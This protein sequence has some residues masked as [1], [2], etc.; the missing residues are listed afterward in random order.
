MKLYDVEISAQNNIA[1]SGQDD[2][3]IFDTS[4]I[5]KRLATEGFKF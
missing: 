3:P 1:N 2:K 5:G 4:P